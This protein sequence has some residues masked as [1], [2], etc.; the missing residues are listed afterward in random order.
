MNEYLNVLRRHYADFSGRARRREYWMFV[1]FNGIVTLLL[2]LLILPYVIQASA[3]Q[4]SGQSDLP[5][6]G[7]AVLALLGAV[8]ITLYSLA[9]LVPSIA[10]CVRRLHDT[11]KSGWLYLLSL[12]PI[13]NLVLLVF[14]CLDSEPGA[15]KWGPNP[16]GVG[17]T[18]VGAPTGGADW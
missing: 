4:A 15:N 18:A 12:V 17:G 14:F 11:G 8:L 6:G 10:V 13:G 7:A 1:L 5:G 2:L 3:A 9:V 16:K